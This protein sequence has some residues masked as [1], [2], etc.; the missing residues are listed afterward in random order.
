MGQS[1]SLPTVIGALLDDSIK[2]NAIIEFCG[3][4][5]GVRE[6]NERCREIEDPER[7]EMRRAR[8]SSTRRDTQVDS[9]QGLYGA[10]W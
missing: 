2:N 7:R 6:E 10:P 3:K 9:G 1:L 8:T 4:V 5:I